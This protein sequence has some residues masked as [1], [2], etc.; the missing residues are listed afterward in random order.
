M[1]TLT[2]KKLDDNSLAESLRDAPAN[3][4]VLLEAREVTGYKLQAASYKLRVTS[5]SLVACGL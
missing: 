5:S 2:N 4:I 3:A 1:L